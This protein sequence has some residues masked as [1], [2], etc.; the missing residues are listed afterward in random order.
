MNYYNIKQSIRE[1]AEACG[2]E[3][4]AT[5]GGC[6]YMVLEWKHLNL[7]L[8][9]D[10]HESGVAWDEPCCIVFYDSPF[11]NCEVGSPQ[12]IYD[13]TFPSPLEALVFIKNFDGTIKL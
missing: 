11:G 4:I 9:D 5:G 3:P 13:K 12:P 7:V 2:M 8:C 1:A 10:M 6:D